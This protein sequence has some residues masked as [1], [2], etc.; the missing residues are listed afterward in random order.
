M[1]PYKQVLT[2]VFG[3]IKTGCYLTL[4]RSEMNAMTTHQVVIKA[5]ETKVRSLFKILLW[6]ALSIL[7]WVSDQPC[8]PFLPKLLLISCHKDLLFNS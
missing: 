4:I 3:P 6:M 1:V 2:V 8:T 7:F 5:L